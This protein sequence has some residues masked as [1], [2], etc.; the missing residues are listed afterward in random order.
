[1]APDR[2]RRR[3]LVRRPLTWTIGIVAVVVSTF[4]GMAVVDGG[5]AD[6]SERAA[7]VGTTAGGSR[8]TAIAPVAGEWA[9]AHPRPTTHSVVMVGDSITHQSRDELHVRLD[10]RGISPTI[11]AIPRATAGLMLERARQVGM[12]RA[13]QVIINVGTNDVVK[14]LSLDGTLTDIVSLIE[15]FPEA[16]CTHLVTINGHMVSLTDHR[17]TARTRTLNRALHYL[18]QEL[19]DVHVIDWA[20]LLAEGT[21]VPLAERL[22]AADSV[23]TNAVGRAALADIY[24]DALDRCDDA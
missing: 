17:L 23:H 11:E 14:G 10:E 24:V 5:V 20:G 19:P 21:D 7:G 1:M 18:A 22:L 4:V 16:R 6:D 2:F 8:D 13:D 12:P 3:P 15:M 9:G